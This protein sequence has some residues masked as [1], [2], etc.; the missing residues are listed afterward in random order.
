M[1]SIE[2]KG[3]GANRGGDDP[4]LTEGQVA[5]DYT[6]LV[7]G[8]VSVKKALASAYENVTELELLRLHTSKNVISS[9]VQS[10]GSA[11]DECV[12]PFVTDIN[13]ALLVVDA[14]EEVVDLKKSKRNSQISEQTL[15]T[16]CADQE[17]TKCGELFTSPDIV[18]QGVLQVMDEESRSWV[19]ARFVLTKAGLYWFMNE[20]TGPL[21][22]DHLT[23]A[24]T[25]IE[26]A[27][28]PGLKLVQ[29]GSRYFS[30]K[31][32][33]ILKA[34]TTE[35]YCEWAIALREAIQ[36]ANGRAK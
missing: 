20:N 2:E 3:I 25:T 13:K 24:R 7:S 28:S 14:E 22:D 5:H 26:Q 27:K 32:G 9:L 10:Y 8:Q 34:P 33:V 31:R 35:E 6:Q 36:S 23:L 4:W 17:T 16:Q 11:I 29:E 12:V 1:E 15:R 19:N 21:P 30:W 18:R